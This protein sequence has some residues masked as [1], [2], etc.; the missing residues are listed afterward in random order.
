M[1]FN[2][3][4]PIIFYINILLNKNMNDYSYKLDKFLFPLISSVD[5]PNIL[6]FGV[7]NGTSTL[8][9]LDICNKNDGHLYSADVIDCSHISN[10]PRWLFIKSRDDEFDLIKEKIPKEIDVV[11]LDSL[12]EA[13]HVNK[14]FY[15]Y[16]NMLKVGGY[17]FIDDISHLPYLKNKERNSFYCEIN[18]RETFQEILAIFNKNSDLFEL[19]FSFY[20]SGLAIIKKVSDQKLNTKV[21]ILSREKSLKNIFRLIWKNLKKG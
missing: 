16:Y 4:S 12:H 11:Y 2:N 9:F 5:K 14:I 15:A 3:I 17:F 1:C 7:Q 20:S 10:N 13:S 6:E 21:N 19:N 18:N 8:K